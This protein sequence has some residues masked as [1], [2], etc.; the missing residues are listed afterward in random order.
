LSESFPPIV[1]VFAP[2]AV[3]EPA[4]EAICQDR[5]PD[6]PSVCDQVLRTA[7][8]ASVIRVFAVVSHF[9]FDPGALTASVDVVV[10]EKSCE[11]AVDVAACERE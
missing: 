3:W 1:E 7:D 8:G 10:E 4:E 9:G 5:V 11:G 6:K 2:S